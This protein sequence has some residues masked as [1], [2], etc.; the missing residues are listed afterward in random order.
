MC[1]QPERLRIDIEQLNVSFVCRRY[2]DRDFQNLFKTTINVVSIFGAAR[3][4]FIQA[5]HCFEI[6]GT[7]FENPKQ[8]RFTFA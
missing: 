5:S 7:V 6:S 4:D 8:S 3:A 1:D 2:L